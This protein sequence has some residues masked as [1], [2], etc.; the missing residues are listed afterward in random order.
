MKRFIAQLVDATGKPRRL[1]VFGTG[2]SQWG[3]E[4]WC[5][6]V[7]RIAAFF[8][9]RYPRLEIEQM[10][11]GTRDALK[12]ER[13]TDHVPLSPQAHPTVS[14]RSRPMQIIHA[15]SADQFHAAIATHA[16]LLIDYHK[17]HCP[18]CRMLALSLQQF[19]TLP[20]AAGIVV[21]RSGWKSLARLFPGAGA[22]PDSDAGAVSRWHRVARLPGF[23]PP[24]V[25]LRAVRAMLLPASP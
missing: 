4:Y 21:L 20:E 25:I 23:Q 17:N 22:A 14:T 2:E 11:H 8:D 19:A 7:R 13:W 9:T 24:A 6:A 12:I 10:P 1:A 18:G 16:R 5:G 15:S 3:P